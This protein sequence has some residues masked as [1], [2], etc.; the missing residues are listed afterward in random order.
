MSES[1]RTLTAADVTAIARAVVRELRAVREA[2]RK[3]QRPPEPEFSE[4][5]RAAAR[6]IARRHGL[7]VRP[8]KK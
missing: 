6:A 8:V 1:A 3:P 5:D 2:E 4:T 7:H